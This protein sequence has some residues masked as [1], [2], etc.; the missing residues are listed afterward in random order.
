MLNHCKM[1]L[2]LAAVG[3]SGLSFAQMHGAKPERIRG[4]IV[5]FK[6][7]TLTVHRASGDTVLIDLNLKSVSLHSSPPCFQ[8]PRWG[9]MSERRRLPAAM[10]K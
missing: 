1:A 2:L 10:E 9:L 8:T 6:G 3:F 5:S 4:D 7:E